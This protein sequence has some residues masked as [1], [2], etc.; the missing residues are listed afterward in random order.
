MNLL[1]FINPIYIVEKLINWIKRPKTEILVFRQKKPVPYKGKGR[2][3]I[4]TRFVWGSENKPKAPWG[5]I[6]LSEEQWPSNNVLYTVTA[7]N[8]GRQIERNI[9]ISLD[10]DKPSLLKVILSNPEK[11]S[12][13]EGGRFASY[14]VLK[15][16]ELFPGEKQSVQIFTSGDSFK[17]LNAW[18]ESSGKIN[19]WLFDIIIGNHEPNKALSIRK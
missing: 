16:N 8:N 1:D 17:H 7:N 10:F 11:C 15:I 6:Y 4:T 12:V 3:K 5:E 18:S 14:I 19:A 13:L 9:Q 2:V